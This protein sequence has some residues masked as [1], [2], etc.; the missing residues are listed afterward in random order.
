MHT[1]AS[2]P[3]HRRLWVK[4]P[5]KHKVIELNYLP[6]KEDVNSFFRDFLLQ[7]LHKEGGNLSLNRTL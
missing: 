7:L 6:L 3:K 1:L 5:S 2:N 4:T